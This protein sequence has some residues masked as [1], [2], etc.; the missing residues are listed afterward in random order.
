MPFAAYPGTGERVIR[1][2]A[3]QV[4]SVFLLGKMNDRVLKAV[5]LLDLE[6]EFLQMVALV[7][8]EQNKIIQAY[9]T[10]NG[11]KENPNVFW[12]G[13]MVQ[14]TIGQTLM[15]G[16]GDH[17][18]LSILMCD[19]NI[20]SFRATNYLKTRGEDVQTATLVISD[21]NK[22]KAPVLVVWNSVVDNQK[23]VLAKVQTGLLT[24]ISRATACRSYQR[25]L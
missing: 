4:D 15:A 22:S 10:L 16:Y 7:M 20:A 17:D 8:K 21:A 5:P 25:M 9:A 18:D 13:D 6:N 1:I 19:D 24:S 12:K 3:E 2:A 14:T 11:L 23:V